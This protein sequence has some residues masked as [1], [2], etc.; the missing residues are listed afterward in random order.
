MTYKNCT[1]PVTC[2]SEKYF[3]YETVETSL[4]A[5]LKTNWSNPIPFLL[6]GHRI[7]PSVSTA[8]SRV[9]TTVKRSS[10]SFSGD[11][12]RRGVKGVDS[13]PVTKPAR[14]VSK[15]TLGRLRT[16]RVPWMIIRNIIIMVPVNCG[17]CCSC[18]CQSLPFGQ[19]IFSQ[20]S[21]LFGGHGRKRKTVRGHGHDSTPRDGR[22][23][24][25]D[26]VPVTGDR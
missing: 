23:H 15:Q 19:E 8:T 12:E 4:S 5:N 6:R 18:S 16:Q 1:R 26:Q 11:T 22:P 3:Y 14:P 20:T 21:R 24:P 7:R 9:K 25:Y 2:S 13:L 10:E 17:R